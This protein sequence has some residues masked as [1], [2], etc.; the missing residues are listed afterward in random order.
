MEK[1]KAL[2]L[3]GLYLRSMGVPQEELD[4]ISGLYSA[5]RVWPSW[6]D[7]LEATPEVRLDIGGWCDQAAS[8]RVSM[9]NLYSEA[10]LLTQEKTKEK[11]N[12]HSGNSL[13][14]FLGHGGGVPSSRLA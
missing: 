12:Q 3:M 7:Y 5:R 13:F 1:A 9:P 8:T 4:L 10:R 14:F 11:H 6:A 2:R